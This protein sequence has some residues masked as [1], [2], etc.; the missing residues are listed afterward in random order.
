[1]SVVTRT[2]LENAS[3]DCQT[4]EDVVNGSEVFGGTG[5]LASREGTVIQ[6]LKK[7]IADLA[8]LDVG[9]LAAAQLNVRMD[10]LEARIYDLENP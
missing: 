5:I 4:L 9:E 7:V 8:E 3:L 2:Q 1:M 10:A 6:T